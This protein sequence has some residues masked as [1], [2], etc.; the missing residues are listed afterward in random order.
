MTQTLAFFFRH[1][2]Y[3]C[4]LLPCNSS[5]YFIRIIFIL[6]YV[7]LGQK[8]APLSLWFF[9]YSFWLTLSVQNIKFQFLWKYF[10][11]FILCLRLFPPVFWFRSLDYSVCLYSNMQIRVRTAQ[12]STAANFG[13]RWSNTL[14]LSCCNCHDK[15]L[16][17]R[18]LIF[19]VWQPFRKD[20]NKVFVYS[21]HIKIRA[22]KN[23]TQLWNP[24]V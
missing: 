14:K 23:W 12:T 19:K 1:A 9:F 5:Y 17:F 8:P 21:L 2:F 20:T 24:F 10:L 3:I 22:Q 11:R 4:T 6:N 13:Q 18:F 7:W 16:L 15:N